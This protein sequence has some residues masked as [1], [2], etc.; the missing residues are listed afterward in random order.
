MKFSNFPVILT[1]R[2]GRTMI[3][4]KEKNFGGF[5]DPVGP[6]HVTQ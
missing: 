1:R 2:G 3:I 4:Q 5:S 6:I